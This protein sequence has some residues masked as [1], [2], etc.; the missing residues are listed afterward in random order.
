MSAIEDCA[1]KLGMDPLQL[2]LKN[3]ALTA[4]SED[5]YHR[6]DT[7]RDELMIAADLIGWKKNWHPRGQGSGTT[8]RGLGLAIHTW[9]G[10]GHES[11]CALTIYPTGSVE[12]QMGTQDLGVGTR[13]AILIVAGD[14][15]GLQL[16]QIELKIGD[17]QY[18]KSGGSGGSTTIGGVSSSTRRAAID[19][20]EQLF[21]KVASALNAKPDDLEAVGGSIRVKSAPFA[22]HEL[23]RCL[24]QA[25]YSA[26]SGSGQESRSGRPD[27]QRR[28]RRG[29]G[30]RIC[31]H[32]NRRGENE[33][34]GL[35]AG[36][37]AHHQHENR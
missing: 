1:A 10:R 4:P 8:K 22:Q 14:T 12:I 27:F 25:R 20:R 11:N 13:T 7:Y 34:N 19:A 17:N 36:L 23:E 35:R 18:P 5:T 2:M 31:G 28:R 29:D 21:A 33:Q 9:G 6:A 37:R 16:N 24:R 26:S 32:R 3:I 15:L 30:R